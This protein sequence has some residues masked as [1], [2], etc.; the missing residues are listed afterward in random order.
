[1]SMAH[2][3]VGSTELYFL[4]LS[5]G[6]YS[7]PNPEGLIHFLKFLRILNFFFFKKVV[8]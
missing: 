6:L 2:A 1:M 4:F 5:N 3:L 8:L 7:C